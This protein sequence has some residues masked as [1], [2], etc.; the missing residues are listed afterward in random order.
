MR[1]VGNKF[2]TRIFTQAGEQLLEPVVDALPKKW[3]L[4]MAVLPDI[5]PAPGLKTLEF[6]FLP[7]CPETAHDAVSATAFVHHLDTGATRLVDFT[8]HKH[9]AKIVWD[10]QKCKF[11]Q[12]MLLEFKHL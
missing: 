3:K 9:A 6:P 7:G 5:L 8:T 4:G 1:D 12:E 10:T 2:L 11:L